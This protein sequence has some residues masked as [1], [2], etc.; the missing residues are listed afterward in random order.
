[1]F[2]IHDVFQKYRPKI[3]NAVG[4]F[5]ERTPALL[6]GLA[7]F[8]GISFYQVPFMAVAAPIL[9]LWGCLPFALWKNQRDLIFRLLLAASLACAGYFY[10]YT[11]DNAIEVPEEGLHGKARLVITDIRKK[12]SSSGLNWYLDAMVQSFETS[13]RE[14]LSD[15]P[16]TLMLSAKEE[17]FIPAVEQEWEV[18]ATLTYFQK[19]DK[20][21][22]KTRK[23][24]RWTP[25]G[26]SWRGQL[27][28]WRERIKR[29]VAD[30]TS[31]V[32]ESSRS[33][34]FLAGMVTGQFD[35]TV[36]KHHFGRFGVQHILAISGF[37][38]SL[39]G[40]IAGFF[41][42]LFMTKR[43]ATGLL[44][45]LLSGYFLILGVT[46][47]VLRAW[48]TITIAIC[49]Y[50]LQRRPTALNS[51][52]IALAAVSLIEPSCY[53]QVGFQCS[54]AIT[55]AILMFYHPS[56]KLFEKLLPVRHLSQ[57]IQWDFFTQHVYIA[58]GAVR[59]ILALT[60][61]VN[62][63][64]IPLL[65]YHFQSFPLF[66]LL[67]N[68]FFPFFVSLSMFFLIVGSL[69][70]AFFET[71]GQLIHTLNGYYTY[72]V[73][74]L[75]LEAPPAMDIVIRT[76]EIPAAIVT[77]FLTLLFALGIAYKSPQQDEWISFF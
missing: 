7:L 73:V 24:A 3:L 12:K 22:L 75:A 60:L 41:L 48:L 68:L 46:A 6:Y 53:G 56:H 27:T 28:L 31:S 16:V 71:L 29:A 43:F 40:A 13:K 8:L 10:A 69:L 70:H 49:A 18:H 35:D 36:L 9:A 30:Y 37:H 38:F 32:M 45:I 55:A 19:I 67:Y 72:F 11:F 25:L 57:A 23:D 59:T 65:I 52:G 58:S 2:F 33:G 42:R 44:G 76:T 34:P 54:F 1:V 47:S 14:I 51:L 26:H 17:N 74:S 4:L 50:L 61:A 5:W 64:A 15:V 63:A 39:L 21:F 62:L 66:S 77:A 20:Y